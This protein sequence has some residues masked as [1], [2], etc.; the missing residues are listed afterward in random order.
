[1]SAVSARLRG[2]LRHFARV[3]NGGQGR[4]WAPLTCR[5]VATG[6]EAGGP[7]PPGNS[8]SG[9]PPPPV[10]SESAGSE[11]PPPASGSEPPPPSGL[12]CGGFFFSFDPNIGLWNDKV[13]PTWRMTFTDQA[14][15]EKTRVPYTMAIQNRGPHAELGLR[16]QH[17]FVSC[18]G[19][20]TE[21]PHNLV[22]QTGW[23]VGFPMPFSVLRFSQFAATGAE[24]PITVYG[25]DFTLGLGLGV[26]TVVTGNGV[27]GVPELSWK[28]DIA[29]SGFVLS[30]LG[31][32]YCLVTLPSTWK[33]FI[34]ELQEFTMEDDQ[35]IEAFSAM[36]I[37]GDG[38]ISREDL[39]QFLQQAST[40]QQMLKLDQQLDPDAIFEFMDVR[41][42]GMVS[43]EDFCDFIDTMAT[44]QEAQES[45]QQMPAG[46]LHGLG[47]G[48]VAG[49]LQPFGGAFPPNPMGLDNVAFRP[50]T[51][52]GPRGPAW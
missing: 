14:T 23:E 52:A 16:F 27:K 37:D 28:G 50:P 19:S 22:I 25:V 49:N 18:D 12:S 40:E 11:V 44:A 17:G 7:P 9:S 10:A 36:D 41:K 15:K 47:S 34:Q 13:N 6:A 4:A 51:H 29:M 20:F 3:S 46:G 26:Q 8:P 24:T 30:V 1:M 45:R 35:A 38:F 32:I 21:V 33:E 39:R 2:T 48:G 31:S 43:F 42:T 5:S